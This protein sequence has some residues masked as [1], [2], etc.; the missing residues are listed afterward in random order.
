[1]PVCSYS[2][3]E[4][5]E[6]VR[7]FHGYAA[8]GVL[9]GGFMVDLAARNLPPQILTDAL[10]ETSK[11]LPDA[12][13]ILT[14]CT[15]GNGWLKIVNHGRFALTLYN[16][17]TGEGVR[18]SVDPIA[19]EKWP[20]IRDWFFKFKSKQEQNI[21]ALM[22]EI[23]EAGASYCTARYVKIAEAVREKKHRVGFTICPCCGEA[24]PLADGLLCLGCQSDPLWEVSRGVATS[25]V[26]MGGQN[27]RLDASPLRSHVSDNIISLVGPSRKRP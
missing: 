9:I 22:A 20:E 13:Q 2:F 23:E 26:A 25:N 1:M 12:I 3:R 21:E 15:I 6:Y 19:L 24:F 8:P 7:S 11:C 10:C 5:V 14:P 18:V 4:Y 17:H 27:S 16:K